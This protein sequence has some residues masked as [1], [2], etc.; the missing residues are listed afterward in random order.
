MIVTKRNRPTNITDEQYRRVVE[1]KPLKRLVKELGMN[2]KAAERIRTGYHYKQ[3][4][5]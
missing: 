2:L 1:W 3:V 5:P 4:S